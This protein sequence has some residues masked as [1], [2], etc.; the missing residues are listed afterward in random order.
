MDQ[1]GL[2]FG[3]IAAPHL[4]QVWVALS[5]CGLCAVEFGVRRE[6]F[7]ASLQRQP[8]REHEYVSREAHPAVSQATH[9]IQEYLQGK[10]RRFDFAIDWTI[11]TSDFQRSAL[12]AVSAIPYGETSTYGEIAA[13]IGHPG[14]ARAVGR[15]NATNP[16]PLVIPCH[17]LIGA[18]RRLLG[19]GGV[20][21][22]YTK[23][24]LLVLEGALPGGKS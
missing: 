9:Q 19:Y 6:A 22:L 17:R 24:W 14:A 12:K 5:E 23:R 16:M 15:A 3:F 11:L 2:V 21:G 1:K 13:K 7:E 8:H 10:R 20:G 18:D 4:G